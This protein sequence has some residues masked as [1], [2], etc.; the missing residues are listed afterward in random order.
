MQRT[1]ISENRIWSQRPITVKVNIKEDA[2]TFHFKNED[3]R[4]FYWIHISD[5]KA[6][7]AFWTNHMK[8]K[9]WYTRGME[10]FINSNLE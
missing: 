9:S 2:I 8:D 7:T 10:D 3:D 5:W 4:E 1:F 6:E